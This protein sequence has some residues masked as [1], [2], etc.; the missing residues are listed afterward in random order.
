LKKKILITGAS[1]FIGKYLVKSLIKKNHQITVVIKKKHGYLFGKKKIKYIFVKNIFKEKKAWW[2][3]KLKKI[4]TVVHL[5]WEAKPPNYQSSRKN[6]DCLIGSLNI[7]SACIEVNVK[8][9]V[10]I[11]T[12]FEYQMGQKKNLSIKTP[13]GPKTL[14]ALCKACLFITLKEI[15]KKSKTSFIW[16]RL[17]YVFGEG[18]H[19]EKL[20]PYIINKL[21]LG[22]KIIINNPNK[23][24][25]YIN[26]EK[27]SD[28]LEKI[29][30]TDKKTLPVYNICS[31]KGQSIKEL[32]N[33]ISK[34]YKLNKNITYKKNETKNFDPMYVVGVNN[35]NL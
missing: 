34:K 25:D 18:D 31:G 16:T 21:K 2:K 5:A 32:T 13:L 17:F 9:F 30:V 26:V 11:G 20:I 8:K 33:K 12:C 4:D 24:K 22:K 7:A 19:K 1:G 28:R 10:G 15:F 29:I 23:I 27:V 35:F 14:Y 6:I 3:N